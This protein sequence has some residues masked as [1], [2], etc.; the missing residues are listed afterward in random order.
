MD[1]VFQDKKTGAGSEGHID[2]GV[3]V[4]EDK[5]IYVMNRGELLRELHKRF[6]GTTELICLFMRKPIAFRPSVSKTEGKPR[7][8]QT[9]KKLRNAIMKKPT[10][11]SVSERHRTQTV[12]MS[13]TELLSG[14]LNQRGLGQL[15]HAQFLKIGISPYIMVPLEEIHFDPSV[16]KVL[17]GRK[18]SY[19]TFRY[20]IAVLIPEIPYIPQEVH[21]SGILRKIPQET[22]K[23]GFAVG[24]IADPKA[25][26]Y[27]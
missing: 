1:P 7:M 14:D 15:Y 4:P 17:Q 21:R 3:I 23:T 24:R 10:K 2:R 27:I 18:Y 19:V 22:C 16:H 6:V 11:E 26:M 8:Q 25:E 20:Y 12:A 13:Q 5:V 9:E